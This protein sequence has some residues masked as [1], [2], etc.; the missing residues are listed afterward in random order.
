VLAS[1]G[2]PLSLLGLAAYVRAHQI[3]IVHC[4]EKPRDAFYGVL[5]GKLTG[6]RSVVHMHVGYGD[7]QSRLTRWALRHADAIVGVSQF[8]AQTIV[9][10]GFPPDRVHAVCNSLDLSDGT[11]NPDADGLPARQALGVPET[12]PV[13][14]IVARLFQWKGHAD[15]IDAVAMVRQAL[16]DVR[17]VIV[18]EEDRRH[19]PGGSYRAQL[20][21][22]IAKLGLAR[23]VV[24]TGYRTDVAAP[25][26]AFD[27]YAMPSIEEP[28]GMVYL[29]AMA[30]R[31]PVVAWANGGALEVVAH[32]QTGLLAETKCVPAL[33]DALQVLLRDPALRRRYGEAGRRRVEQTFTP[34]RMCREMI[35]V[36]S[37]ALSAADR[38]SPRPTTRQGA[39]ATR[40]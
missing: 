4:T 35:E 3:Q 24:F 32:G 34:A 19:D 37:A 12:A 8:T 28:F 20:D 16:P 29:E 13:V 26:A 31:K 10:A 22:Q 18:G 15:L 39:P 38:R 17:L 9:D 25:M 11:W 21:A 33:A 27:V 23:N 6:A 30:L 14:G 1:G 5:L 7:W 36:Y 2:V 40:G